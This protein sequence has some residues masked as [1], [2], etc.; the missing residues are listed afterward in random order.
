MNELFQFH[1]ELNIKK[2]IILVVIILIL[3]FLIF[4]V[5]KM[6]KK[7][8]EKIIEDSEPNKIFTSSDGTIELVLSKEYGFSE[9]KP[10]QNYILELR[11]ENNLD[12]FVSHKELIE[13]RNFNNIVSSDRDSY[14]KTFNT[15][16]NLSEISDLTVNGNPAYSYSLHYLDNRVAYYLQII[17][18]QTDNGYYIIDVEF[19]LDTLNSNHKIIN[20]L[21]TNFKINSNNVI[22]NS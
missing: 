19:P 16:S 20:D 4:F 7:A 18:I 13:N 11:T 22:V 14:I 8:K 3:I 10:R 6:F 1:K 9:Y 12:I 5:P 15:Y 17:W 2:V 21:I